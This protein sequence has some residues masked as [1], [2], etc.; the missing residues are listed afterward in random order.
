MALLDWIF[1]QSNPFAPDTYGFFRGLYPPDTRPMPGG[2]PTL[3]A[4]TSPAYLPLPSPVSG[5][6]PL[7]SGAP[8]PPPFPKT[9]PMDANAAMRRPMGVF[10]FGR[11]PPASATI[12]DSASS[13]DVSGYAR[14]TRTIESGSPQGDYGAIGPANKSGQRAY[15]AY[16]IMDFNIPT[17]TKEVLGQ[18]MTPQQFLQ[19]P[20]AQDQVYQA[21]F[22]ALAQKYGPE[23]AARAWF[24][25]SPTGTGT[26]VT[27]TSADQY[28]QR[29]RNAYG[30]TA[31]APDTTR[32]MYQPPWSGRN[33]VPAA[34]SIPQ[35]AANF[36]SPDALYSQNLKTATGNLPMNIP[37][38]AASFAPA[39]PSPYQESTPNRDIAGLASQWANSAPLGQ[40]AANWQPPNLKP[41]APTSTTPA[42]KPF[43]WGSEAM[44]WPTL[45][46][47]G[48]GLM[49]P[50]LYGFRGSLGQGLSD[51]TK[52]M[53]TAPDIALKRQL[54]RAEI[55][56]K[57][58]SVQQR[59]AL[60]KIASN[61]DM[62][63]ALRLIAGLGDTGKFVDAFM[64]LDSATQ[65]QLAENESVKTLLTES[66]KIQA[67]TS[68]GAI[69]G[70][71]ALK[72]AEVRAEALAKVDAAK[73][74]GREEQMKSAGIVMQS[75]DKASKQAQSSWTTGT[76]GVILRQVPG[77][78]ARD[79]EATVDTIKAN[80]GFDKL[81]QMRASSPTGGALG[82]VSDFENKLLQ[83][84]VGN[85]ETSQSK[86]QFLE[87]L[88][89]VKRIYSD[90]INKGI[91]PGEEGKYF[92]GSPSTSTPEPPSGFRLVR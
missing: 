15:G 40:M 39:E 36:A 90:I 68:P 34:D 83:S 20:Q 74:A 49:Q 5:E 76:P 56:I 28:V 50:T 75:I 72:G 27:G 86:E 16:Q 6:T 84:V 65:R 81:Q 73:E 46:A 13:N 64:K 30:Q 47:F 52:Y 57:E 71:A 44:I 31:D 18:S 17:W 33:V 29:W 70:Q 21:K 22:G 58:A 37:A 82:Q 1:G 23:G 7:G 9:P 43:D 14:A 77:T 60:Q 54:M 8:I 87:N 48:Q 89:R 51:A 63:Q 67:Q 41:T 26:D 12:P 25:G 19:N 91:R 4:P 10:D 32:M 69:Q 45:A 88:G 85:L 55:G 53:Q 35:A 80:I 62:P 38:A 78:A 92:A 24:T 2:A 42:R 59:E 66:A 79:L 61:G 3:D 11:V